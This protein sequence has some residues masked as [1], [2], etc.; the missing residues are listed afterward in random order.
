MNWN[1][2][3]AVIYRHMYNFKHSYD[4]AT[5]VFYWPLMDILLWGFASVYLAN[6]SSDT[7]LVLL[8]I[9][10]GLMLNMV[11]WR[12]Q[13]D[14]TVNLLE[15]MWA[16]NMINMF[17]SPL[18]LREWI[19]AVII[20]GTIKM[21]MTLSMSVILA[22]IIYKTNLF[23]LGFYLIPFFAS[24]LMTGWGI[25]LFISGIIVYFG[26]KIQTL[27][28]SGISVITPFSGV[29]YPISVLPD[30]AQKVSAFLPTSYIFEG[31]RGYLS[32]K[33]IPM[34]DLLISF[35]LNFIYLFLS[36]CFFRR[37]FEKSREL[38]L[39]RLE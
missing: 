27:A 17:A 31:M 32:T 1:L 26:T 10:S 14:I 30:W 22:L 37:M 13:Y 9:L 25:G 24:L 5:D 23:D 12:A 38:G 35:G 11:M 6:Q 2:V 28:W 21:C 39:G 4:R 34:N 20:L 36:L 16:K 33:Q 15:E 8:I 18:R 29:F 7:P 3:R 19:V